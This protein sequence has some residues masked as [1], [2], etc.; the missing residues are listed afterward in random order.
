MTTQ[1][2]N[3]DF[4][5]ATIRQRP[6]DGYLNATDMCQ[7]SG[8]RLNNYLRIKTTKEFLI[9]LSDFIAKNPVTPI[10]V[11]EQNQQLIQTMQGGIPEEQGTWVHPYVSINLAQWC[12]PI[13]AVL[14][15][16]WVFELLTKGS[17][18]LNPNEPSIQD[19]IKFTQTQAQ[20]L[21]NLGITGNAKKI[22][23][24]NSVKDE[25]DCDILK[26][27]D[28]ESKPAEVQQA[29]LNPTKIAAIPTL[30]RHK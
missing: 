2:I 29:L 4:H 3:R 8:K 26:I 27:F 18:S 25:F 14:V 9:E 21:D 12:S 6:S 7:A 16:N 30:N 24:N 13:F 23:L 15:T 1:L 22:S 28:I 5:G 11:T 19:V 20:K 10:G 17:V